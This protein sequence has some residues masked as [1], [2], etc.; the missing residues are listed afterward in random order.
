MSISIIQ[1]RL[2]TYSCT[3]ARDE[4]HAVREIAQEVVLSAL[5]RTDF[6][7]F[8]AFHGG[9]CLRIFYGLNRFSEDLDFCLHERSAAFALAPFLQTVAEEVRAY[10]FD[11]EIQDRSNAE[12]VVK[13]AFIKDDSLG[14]VLQ[15][16]FLD[17]KRTMRKIRIKIEVD[18]NPPVGATS[19][20]K[21]L[22]FPFVSSATVH[23]LPSLFSGKLHA[24]L[25]REY[26]KGRDWYDFLWYSSRAISHNVT[27]LSAA[28][29]Q[30]GPWA[31]QEVEANA[32]WC[33]AEIG[34]KIESI[35]WQAAALEVAPFVKQEEQRSLG[36]WSTALFLNQT[37]K[38]FR[39]HRT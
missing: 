6:F 5:G 27:M 30:S 3:T 29:C 17:R 22:D 4:D 1:S 12:A 20:L 31:G 26:L 37:G 21:Y 32:A 18:T 19:E 11:P 10:G 16:S 15:F 8:A 14:K 13:K 38:V 34:R 39:A 23:D 25:C 33:A 9:T 7:R 36:L 24:L 28:L 2:E 35:D